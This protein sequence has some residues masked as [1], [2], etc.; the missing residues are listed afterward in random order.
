MKRNDSLSGGLTGVSPLDKFDVDEA[1][2]L[3]TGAW[4]QVVTNYLNPNHNHNPN[5]AH[6]RL[7]P[8]RVGG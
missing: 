5:P 7:V 8:G 6:Q 2:C 4:F 1:D 3:L